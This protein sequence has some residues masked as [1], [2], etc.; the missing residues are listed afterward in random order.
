MTV[1]NTAIYG[2]VEA[3]ET[4]L[5]TRENGNSYYFILLIL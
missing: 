1:K 3:T 2:I 4:P 5:G